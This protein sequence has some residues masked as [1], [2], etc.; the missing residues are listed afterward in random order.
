MNKAWIRR[1]GF[2]TVTLIVLIAAIAWTI[3]TF[4]PVAKVVPVQAVSLSVVPEYRIVVGASGQLW[5]KGDELSQGSAAYFYTANPKVT[6]KPIIQVSGL[7]ADKIAGTA[8]TNLVL[9]SVNEKGLVYWSKTLKTSEIQP[10][11]LGTDTMNDSSS[12]RVTLQTLSFEPASAYEQVDAISKELQFQTGIFQVLVVTELQVKGLGPAEPVE[13]QWV[14]TLPVT[15]QMAAFSIPPTKEATTS[16]TLVPEVIG[17]Y[18]VDQVVKAA[19]KQPIP[20]ASVVTA[21]VL[22][23]IGIVIRKRGQASALIAHRKYKDWITEGNADVKNRFSI[24]IYSLEGLVDLA[25]DLDKRVIYDSRV[26]R[27]YV[28]TEDMVYVHDPDRTASVLEN[29]PQLG[30]LLLE[31]GLIRPEQLETGLYY[32][33]RLGTRL[34]ESLMALGFIDENT[35]FSTLA[36]QE[37]VDYVEVNPEVAVAMDEWREQLSLKE[38]KTLQILPLGRRVDGKMVIACSEAGKETVKKALQEMFGNEV[39]LV[40]SRPSAIHD[41][42]AHLEL[43]EAK[44][45][46]EN[47]SNEAMNQSPFERLSID[48]INL[49]KASYLRGH[50]EAEHLLSAAGLTN[51]HL[52]EGEISTLLKG[53]DKATGSMDWQQRQENKLPTLLTVLEKS[54]YLTAKTMTWAEQEAQIQGLTTEQLLLENHM[55]AESTIMKARLLLAA[56]ESLLENR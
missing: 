44:L 6:V 17:G 21:L 34:G 7:K 50:I 32:Q 14:H 27:Y 1:N 55:V 51:R 33:Q 25:I 46:T 56:L 23:V 39:I 18:S 37:G 3:G 48:A 52:N 4:Q 31:K 36:A 54:N 29:K 41:A 35:L 24:G 43:I 47:R 40:A 26:K 11:N 19:Y 45:V 16:F 49:F 28:L 5:K 12:S 13:R 8:Q 2:V 10:F 9:Q 30:K 38:A 42:I 15:L 22:L 53:L 20:L